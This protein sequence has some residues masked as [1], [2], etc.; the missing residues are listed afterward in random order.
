M[1]DIQNHPGELRRLQRSESS[2]DSTITDP[3]VD[4]DMS[5]PSSPPRATSTDP[6][7]ALQ[8]LLAQA[9]PSSP[10]ERDVTDQ[11]RKGS[12]SSKGDERSLKKEDFARDGS[13]GQGSLLDQTPSAPSAQSAPNSTSR[14]SLGNNGN[15]ASVYSG[16][17]MKNIKKDDGVP[18]W[19]K[20][21]QYDFLRAIFEDDRPVF[22]NFYDGTKRCTFADIYVDAMARSSKTSK[23]LKDKLLTDRAA[24][25]NMAMVCLLVNVGRMNTTLN[26]FPEMRAQLRTYH[27]IPCLQAHQDSSTYKQL[28]DAPRL[29]SILKGA[30]EEKQ[31]PSTLDRLKTYL[32]PRSNP[33]HLVFLLAQDALKLSEL[34]FSPQLDF[35]DLITRTT[36]SSRSRAQGFLWLMWWYLESDFSSKDAEQNPF[37]PGQPPEV[38]GVNQKLPAFEYLT[39][40]QAAMEN[41]DT[42]EELDYG[43]KK[44]EE[45]RQ[46]IENEVLT[47]APH[48]RRAKKTIKAPSEDRAHSPLH[49]GMSPLAPRRDLS[50]SKS[51]RKLSTMETYSDT[52]RT[53]SQSPAQDLTAT[54]TTT[55]TR[56]AAGIRIIQVLNGGDQANDSTPPATNTTNRPSRS[57][58]ARDRPT[59]GTQRLIFK[60]KNEYT[61][62]QPSPGSL[63]SHKD[64]NNSNT[65]NNNNPRRSRPLTAHQVAVERNRQERIDFILNQRLQGVH[66]RARKVRKQEGAMWRAWMRHEAKGGVMDYSVDEGLGFT[67]SISANHQSADNNHPPS[68]D[69]SGGGPTTATSLGAAPKPSTEMDYELEDDYGEEAAAYAAAFRRAARRLKRWDDSDNEVGGGGGKQ[70]TEVSSSSSKKVSNG[71]AL[72]SLPPPP[73]PPAVAAVN[74]NNNRRSTETRHKDRS[75]AQ[76]ESSNKSK[77]NRTTMT[78]RKGASPAIMTSATS[79][80]AATAVFGG[81]A[82]L[83]QVAGSR[84]R[85]GGAREV[86]GPVEDDDDTDEAELDDAMM[87]EG[88][89]RDRSGVAA[90]AAA[91]PQPIDVDTEDDEE[92]EGEEDADADADEME[93]DS[94]IDC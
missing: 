53:Q 48:P 30:S 44:Q 84:G 93:T 12:T 85:G 64:D 16:N 7:T 33:V 58:P 89:G 52:D 47:T 54:T 82:G 25:A 88:E 91:A 63:A 35:F 81:E 94:L 28:Q 83:G 49:D 4:L 27:A 66:K 73:P 26:F 86:V 3:D 38:D 21:I 79:T 71:P 92:M 70:K 78:A 69:V 14:R 56:P 46:I 67:G 59:G 8:H 5:R 50:R 32:A 40:E 65:T 45:R 68:R 2:R 51:Q 43:H 87:G 29:K 31:E 24:A 60:S 39:E 22:T 15:A 72:S 90:A 77:R 75:K 36:L 17:K 62:D 42:E 61:L 9:S 1:D 20:D 37:G 18:L 6:R 76:K 57:R 19:R 55:S 11:T 10:T 34:H 80:T 23:I 74:N 13:A 41:V